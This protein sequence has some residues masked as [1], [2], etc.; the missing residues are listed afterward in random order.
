ML[1]SIFKRTSV[2]LMTKVLNISGAQQRTIASN[3]SNVMTPGYRAKEVDFHQSLKTA[4]DQAGLKGKLD[5]QRHIPIGSA[6]SDKQPILV[7]QD[8]PTPDMEKEMA[9]SA[10]NQLLYA[11]AARIVSGNFKAIRA[12]IRGRF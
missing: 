7:K 10:E 2:G 4:M 1:E 11:A 9:K 12:C 5:D 6:A 8:N 3:I